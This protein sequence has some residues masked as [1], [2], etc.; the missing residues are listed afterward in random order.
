MDAKSSLLDMKLSE[1]DKGMRLFYKGYNISSGSQGLV[2]KD[3][4]L[5]SH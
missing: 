1:A 5:E 4:N 3:W 2:C